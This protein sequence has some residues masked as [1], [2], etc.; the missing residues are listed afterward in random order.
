YRQAVTSALAAVPAADITRVTTYWS[1]GSP[2]LVSTDR[3]ATYAALQLAGS[4]DQDRE[5]AYKKIKDA[6]APA[7]AGSPLS[8]AGLSAQVGGQVP[9][10]VAINA[11]VSG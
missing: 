5:S 10:E 7:S 1:S 8:R 4:S 2:A 9:T 3:H 6:F 11:E